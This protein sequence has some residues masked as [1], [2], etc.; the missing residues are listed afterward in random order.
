MK[1]AI[2]D[3]LS[4]VVKNI[5][6]GEYLYL[7]EKHSKFYKDLGLFTGWWGNFEFQRF[8]PFKRTKEKIKKSLELK[9]E[10]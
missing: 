3:N 7:C 9:E 4:V 6:G 5:K 2:C 1:C 10:I 8:D